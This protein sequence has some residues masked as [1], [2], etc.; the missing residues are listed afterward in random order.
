MTSKA[1]QHNPLGVSLRPGNS[2]LGRVLNVSLPPGISCRANAPCYKEG[3]YARKFYD[4]RAICENAW[5]RNWEAA[6]SHM[7]DYFEFIRAMISLKQP[8]LFRWHVS[9]DIPSESYLTGMMGVAK[10]CP[11]TK[12]LCF[13][14]QYELIS[15]QPWSAHPEHEAKNLRIVLSMWPGLA[16]PR[17]MHS[18]PKAWMRDPKNPDPRIPDDALRCDGGCSTCGRCWNLKPGESIVFDKH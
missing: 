10:T 12:F 13:T 16:L 18:F 6:T 1:K 7:S 17:D 15:E 3:C 5:N 2:K 11:N 9:G 14:K 4:R 8:A